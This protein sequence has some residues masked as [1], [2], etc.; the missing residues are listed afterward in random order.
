MEHKYIYTL[1]CFMWL[2]GST[3]LLADMAVNDLVTTAEWAAGVSF[4][5]GSLLLSLDAVNRR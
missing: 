5:V 1:S 2:V 3:A 4:F